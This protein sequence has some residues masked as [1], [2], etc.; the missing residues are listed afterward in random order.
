MRAWAGPALPWAMAM[1]RQR[2]ELTVKREAVTTGAASLKVY[3]S[4]ECSL[5]KRVR[6][7]SAVRRE[8]SAEYWSEGILRYLTKRVMR[9]FIE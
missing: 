4:A 9:E 6:M 3:G 5:M 2:V 1:F 8:L 7:I